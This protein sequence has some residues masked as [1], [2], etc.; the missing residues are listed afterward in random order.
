MLD[1][2]IHDARIAD[3]TGRGC[4]GG[5]VGIADGRIVEVG[6]VATPA[7]RSI[8]AGGLLLTP[9]FVD[10]HT[11]YD[12]QVSWDGVLAPSS[13]HGVTSIAMGNCGVG[14]A[15]VRADHHARLI[16]LLEGVEDIPGTALAEGLSWDWESFPDYLDA[17][18]RRHYAIDVG[19]QVPHAALRTYVMGEAG[20][21]HT[22]VPSDDEIERM[23]ELT[24]EAVLAGAIG[25]STS[26]SFA[27]RTIEGDNI[28]TLTASERE[29]GFAARA[30]RRAGTGVLQ[31]IS[32][33]YL[34]GGEAFVAG[35]LRLIRML[36][37]LSGR[38]LSF[39]LM[40]SPA[41]PERWRELIAHTAKLVADGHH[42]RTQVAP[43]PVGAI[44]GLAGTLNPFFTTATYRQLA[45]LSL[46]ERARR[47]ARPETKARILREHAALDRSGMLAIIPDSFDSLFR[48]SDPVDYEPCRESS[49]AA[50]ARRL[51]R[52][53]AEYGYDVLL[54]D[55]GR[56]LLYYPVMN[57][58][59]GNL[60]VTYAMMT[61]ANA[62]FGLSDGGAH[63]GSICDASFT[64]S[65]LGLWTRGNKAG[66]RI[67]I[68]MLVNGYTQRNAAHVGWNDRGVIAPGYLADLNIIDLDALTLPP[69]RIVG[70]L[71]AGGNRL[72]QAARG[73]RHTIKRGE[74]TFED[75]EWTGALPGRLVRGERA[76]A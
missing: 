51:G 24:Y 19:A 64:T 67:P 22:A 10:I 66:N 60:D 63:C 29:L 52:A 49:V 9:G 53:P 62:L 39:S 33:A 61:S 21:D 76:F 56:R 26:R 37:E 40:Q 44:M 48:M 30:L 5:D 57:Y 70:D 73:Y 34:G 13:Q 23:E 6:R 18:D 46:D 38:P 59:D 31:L 74:V 58:V 75:G 7:R 27:H 35:E 1:L 72:L 15:P 25:F 3:G 4:Y 68:E 45:T 41:A 69:P 65:T 12:G 28:G 17:L 11:H 36:A 2:R 54:E 50:E 55:D 20:A 32:D 16:G 43:R 71:P 47:F 8:D 42:V 14:F